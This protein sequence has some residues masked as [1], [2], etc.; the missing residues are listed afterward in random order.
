M[1]IYITLPNGK[2]VLIDVQVD[3]TTVLDVKRKIM[4][5]QGIAF[6]NQILMFQTQ[7]L[8]NDKKLNHY[9]IDKE[10]K[11]ELETIQSFAERYMNQISMKFLILEEMKDEQNRLKEQLIL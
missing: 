4:E 10:A 2:T 11:L 3:K 5:K 8:Q 1:Q 7:I 6:E 9:Q